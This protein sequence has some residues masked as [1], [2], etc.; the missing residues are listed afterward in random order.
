MKPAILFCSAGRRA[1]LLMDAKQTLGDRCRIVATDNNTTAPALYCA[2]ARYVVPR[3][4]EPGYIDVILDICKKEN[5]KAVTTLIDPEIEILSANRELF[6]KNGIIP[7]CPMDE[8]SA[9]CCFNK[10]EMFKYLTSKGIP[11]PLTFHDLDAFKEAHAKGEIS[12]PV[13]MKPIC[14]SGS[15]GAHRVQSM[16]QLEK[17]WFSGEHDYII[18]ELM[19]GGDR[20][21]DIYVDTISHRPVAV[22]SKKK[23][24]TRIGGASKTI[25]FKDEKLFRF[26]EEVF[27]HFKFNGPLDMDVFVKDG[28]YLLSE[29]NPRFGGAYLHAYG[30]GVDFFELIWNNINGIENKPELGNYEEDILMMMY[31]NVVIRKRQDLVNDDFTTI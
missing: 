28:E 20:D 14:G 3:I 13:F 27:S 2:D 16:E 29:I 1:T 12:F 7:L 9:K 31:D 26:V 30:A 4:N 24:E 17:D 11:T 18:Q 23:I 22:F 5:V 15:V 10:W 25:S 8:I 6:L 19:T 21:A